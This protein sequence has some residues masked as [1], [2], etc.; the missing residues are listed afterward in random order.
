MS[1][2]MMPSG[3]TVWFTG[4]AG[5]GKSTLAQALGNRLRR[6]GQSPEILDGAEV[7]RFLGIG[8]AQSK[9]ERNEEARRLGWVCKLVTRGGGVVLQSA[10]M[11][12]YRETRDEARRQIHRFAEVFVEC[13]TDTLIARDRTG[14]YKRALSGELKNLPGIS[15]PYEPPTHPEV[16]ID[17]SKYTVDEAVEHLVG[18]LVALRL[19]DMST[20][21]LKSRPKVTARSSKKPLPPPPPRAVNAGTSDK[22]ATRA[23]SPKP[24]AKA[25]SVKPVAARASP[26]A[27]SAGQ[28]AAKPARSASKASPSGKAREPA[29]PAARASAVKLGKT[30]R[31]AARTAR[32]EPRTAAGTHRSR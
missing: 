25:G 2:G 12:P 4:M 23:A 14:Q 5:S 30:S 11:S 1:V 17:T 10:V 19:L 16:I 27:R 9:D 18:Q 20:V 28:P 24:A 22:P 6:L 29:R 26:P 8:K 13:P 21:G 15:E 7:E 31:P 32:A 3:F